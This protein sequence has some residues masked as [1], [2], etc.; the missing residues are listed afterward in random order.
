MGNCPTC[1]PITPGI[2]PVDAYTGAR[3]PADTAPLDYDGIVGSMP[4]PQCNAARLL[5]RQ[6]APALLSR[7]ADPDGFPKDWNGDR[8]HPSWRPHLRGGGL[9]DPKTLR[10]VRLRLVD[11]L[12]NQAGRQVAKQGA[13]LPE[14][15][16]RSPGI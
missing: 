9:P 6:T 5:V 14:K 13:L 8:E 16:R 1:S 3:L 4:C 10:P 2:V 7:P 12:T 15:G 11:A